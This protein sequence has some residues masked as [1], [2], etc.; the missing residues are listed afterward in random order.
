MTFI[1]L[2][3]QTRATDE[4][5]TLRTL[6]V[7]R[8]G[9]PESVLEKACNALADANAC[10][11]TF[12]AYSNALPDNEWGT[13]IGQFKKVDMPYDEDEDDEDGTEVT[14]E[15]FLTPVTEI[16][17]N[18][19]WR[20]RKAQRMEDNAKD[21]K[22]SDAIAAFREE[23]DTK[24]PKTGTRPVVCDY[25]EIRAPPGCHLLLLQYNYEQ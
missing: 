23:R 24:R 11:C 2:V 12:E 22:Q 13:I 7:R 20:S 15:F 25:S 4:T 14:P 5:E 9:A 18:F 16:T 3:I 6:R 10:L 19:V 1:H 17:P 21:A 8:T